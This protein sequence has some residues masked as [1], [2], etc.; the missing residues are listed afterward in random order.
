MIKLLSNTRVKFLLIFTSNQ[1]L[2]DFQIFALFM[3]QT[4]L[5]KKYIFLYLY[6]VNNK[7]KQ[8]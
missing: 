6:C 2:V 5:T 4:L 1:I 8:S 3:L 7:P